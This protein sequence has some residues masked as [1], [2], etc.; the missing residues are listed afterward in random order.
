MYRNSCALAYQLIWLYLSRIKAVDMKQTYDKILEVL[1]GALL[2]ASAFPL[3][4]FKKLK[5]LPVPQHYSK[6]EVDIWGTRNVFVYMFLVAIVVYA[7]LSFR[8]IIS[9]KIGR[10]LKL[11]VMV[12][13]GFLA[14]STYLIAIG[15]MSSINTTI[16]WVIL[17]LAVVHL[18]LSL[19]LQR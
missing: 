5:G 1:S 19:C 14:I 6:G 13:L 10:C 3:V 16:Q 4:M 2:C 18:I 17:A 12:W 7:L 9:P 8:G 11:W 15:N